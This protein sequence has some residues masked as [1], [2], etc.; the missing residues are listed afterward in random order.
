MTEI[1]TVTSGLAGVGK[2]QF[3]LNLALELVR[4]G[5]WVGLFHDQV[6]EHPVDDLLY[7]PEAVFHRLVNGEE[8]PVDVLRRGYQGAD[9]ISCRLPLSAWSQAD[10][11][12]IAHFIG[13]L[14][15]ADHYD[16]LIIDTSGMPGHEQLA[17]CLASPV[18]IL[19]VTPEAAA[20]AEAF[21]LLRILR[22]NG[23]QGL[24]RLLVNRAPY[25][26]DATE[27]HEAFSRQVKTWLDM[28]IPLLDV[29]LEDEH[30]QIAQQSRQAF[31]TVFPESDAAASL[32]VIADRLEELSPAVQQSSVRDYW[33]R[34]RGLLATPLILPGHAVL[35]DTGMH[36]VAQ[37]TGQQ[38][39]RVPASPA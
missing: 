13:N 26:V 14:D 28:D 2:S 21:A 35:D 15:I 18:V 3:A 19:V 11:E 10:P 38:G 32:M 1:L 27:I 34:V 24:L 6:E 20:Q 8:H 9:I 37:E 4:R 23:Y 5:R 29:M 39:K 7:L 36:P 25:A 31:S 30:V 22:L 33:S 12:R 17:C 16:D